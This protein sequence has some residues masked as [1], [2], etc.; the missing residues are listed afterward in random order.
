MNILIYPMLSVDEINTDSNYIIIKNM[1]ERMYK[2][3]NFVLVLNKNKRY[4]KDGLDKKCRIIYISQ[5]T[6]KRE[7]VAWYNPSIVRKI[8][9]EYGIQLVFNNVVEQGHNIK[10]TYNT[11]DPNYRLKVI[12]YHHYNIHP[13]FGEAIYK[14]MKH[15]LLTQLIGSIEVDVNYFHSQHSYNMFAEEYNKLFKQPLTN[16]HVELGKHGKTIPPAKRHDTYTFM[17]NHRLAGY[18]NFTETIE[19]FDRLYQHNPKFQVIFTIADTANQKKLEALPYARIIRTTKHED[20][21]NELAKCHANVTNSAHETY[22]IAIVESMQAKQLIIAPNGVTFPELL[23]KK[24]LFNTPEEQFEM[25]K[26]AVDNR[27]SDIEHQDLD[28]AGQI[29]VY[30][31]LLDKV[32][33]KKRPLDG[34]KN[35]EKVERAFANVDKITPMDAFRRLAKAI[36]VATQSFP[37]NKVTL[38]LE[39][40]GYQYNRHTNTYNRIEIKS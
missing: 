20:Y 13:S 36:N 14:S 21:I 8:C 22:C 6:S 18:K 4:I 9:D 38:L 37:M 2:E 27:I 26:Q 19:M 29:E 16:F 11:I 24:Y 25:M 17:Y 12:N 30:R 39:D 1:V 23:D 28:E 33:Y 31:H 34:I 7:A 40:M 3:H 5:P 15:T 32:Q 10:N 35:R